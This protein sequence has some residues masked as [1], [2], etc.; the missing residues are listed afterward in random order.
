LVG[1]TLEGSGR[2]ENVGRKVYYATPPLPGK[3]RLIAN[4]HGLCNPPG[5]ACGYWTHAASEQG[6]LVCPEGNG[7][8]G[9]GGPP[10]WNEPVGE[11]D[12][13]LETSVDRVSAQ[14]EG[15]VS[16]EGAILTGFSLGAWVAPRIAAM[17][18]GRW[19]YL[20]LNEADVKLTRATLEKAGVVAVVMMA[21]ELGSQLAGERATV[22]RLQREGFPAKL[23]VMPKAGHYY[24]GNIDELMTQAMEFVLGSDAHTES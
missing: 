19:R 2:N 10:T 7:T 23:I 16:R 11:M 20:I 5:Y 14:Y 6:F 22:S 8:C 9:A 12:K 21:G 4:L 1:R 3:H 17:H 13:D 24:S 15:E 18:P